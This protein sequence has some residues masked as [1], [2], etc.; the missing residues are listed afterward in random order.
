ME[1]SVKILE[2]ISPDSIPFDMLFKANRPVIL[3]GLVS[4]WRLVKAGKV[5]AQKAMDV[6]LSH[7]SG[8]PVGVYIGAPET[9][10]RFF[11]IRIAQGLIT[12]VNTLRWATFFCKFAKI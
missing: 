8:K 2:N 7:S 9:K 10:A 1:N 4:G 6:L 5:S 11:T 3:K 12:R